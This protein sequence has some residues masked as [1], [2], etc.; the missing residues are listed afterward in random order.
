MLDI[1]RT[2]AS[3]GSTASSAK[4]TACNTSSMTCSTHRQQVQ[5]SLSSWQVTGGAGN[6]EAPC[7]LFAN[8]ANYCYM[9]ATAAALHWAMRAMGCQPSDF[10][11]LRPALVA[12]SR[13][14]RL[15][16]PTHH[17][18][19]PLLRGWR[20][21]TQQHD[22]AEFMSHVTDPSA[23]ALVGR[24]QARCLEGGRLSI[25]DEGSSAPYIGVDITAQRDLQSALNAWHLQQ[26]IHA[27]TNSPKLLCLQLGRF[28]HE[29]SRT[30]K[31]RHRCYVPKR[32]QVPLFVNDSLECTTQEYVLCSGIVHVGDTATSGHYRAMCVHSPFATER[33]EDSSPALRY[34][35]CDDDR[36]ASLHSPRLDSLLDHNLYVVL[37]SRLDPESGPPGHS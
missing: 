14:R 22:A 33:F 26:Y 4:K 15:E 31:V 11:S 21:P 27:L 24:W 1:A 35:L 17:D 36:Q 5:G 28:R 8:R 29:G 23:A 2:G 3:A 12:I 7:Y 20:R 25:R 9:N 32:L 34:T 30:V 19:K 10:G 6:L 16:I 13:L 37:Y 18:W